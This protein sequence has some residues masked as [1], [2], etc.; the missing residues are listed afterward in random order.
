MISPP[1]KKNA[2]YHL[3]TRDV[4]IVA[5]Y[6]NG[7]VDYAEVEVHVNDG[8]IPGTYH[9]RSREESARCVSTRVDFGG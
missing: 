3:D 8:L 6:S 9:F 4:A 7:G 2:L 5:Y 1:A